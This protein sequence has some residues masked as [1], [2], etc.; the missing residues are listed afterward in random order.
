MLGKGKVVGDAGSNHIAQTCWGV[1]DPNRSFG[2]LRQLHSN[3]SG[4]GL[5]KGHLVCVASGQSSTRHARYMATQK[6]VTG[7]QK[8]PEPRLHRAHGLAE[9]RHE[10]Q[11]PSDALAEAC[12]LR[13]GTE[14]GANIPQLGASWRDWARGQAAGPPQTTGSLRAGTT[15]RTALKALPALKV[16]GDCPP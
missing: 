6:A 10:L 7:M 4:L 13:R 8:G 1:C 3:S 16:H 11:P 14:T 2:S 5:N 15:P 9:R 12:S